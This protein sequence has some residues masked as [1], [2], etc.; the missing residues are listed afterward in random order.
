[1]DPYNHPEPTLFVPRER[2]FWQKLGG[3]SLSVSVV[4]HLLLLAV[5]VIWVFKIIPPPPPKNVDFMPRSGGGGTPS[6]ESHAKKQQLRIS[7][8]NLA[9]VVAMGASS[10]LVLPEPDNISQMSSVGSLSAGGLSAGLGGTGTGG[11]KGSGDGKGFGDGLAAG[12]STGHGNKNPFGM[13]ELTSGGLEG[14]F[15]DLKQ[16]KD[17]KPSEITDAGVMEALKDITKR[18]I[19]ERDFAK[20]FKAPGKLY[21]TKFLIPLM[22]AEEAPAAFDAQ[23]YVQP[24]RW[25]VVYRGVVKAPKSGKFSFVG[26]GD[27]VLVVRFNNRLVFDHGYTL[28]TTGGRGGMM[29]E[30]N[31]NKDKSSDAV[32]NFK[33]NSPMPVPTQTYKYATTGRLNREVDGLAVGPEFQVNA[34]SSYPIEIMISEIPGG[35]FST[36]LLIQESGVSYPKD[37]AGYPILPLFRLDHSLPDPALTGEA[38]P[39]AMDGPVWKLVPGASFRDI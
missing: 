17:L 20:Y 3:G 23:K 11:G 16:D 35:L 38:P 13:A 8:P 18:G 14:S 25:V 32:K 34:G 24:K 27:D 5:G 6:A 31:Y 4:L 9:R 28:A 36:A 22:S 39:Y 1:M 10:S 12:M 15:Y 29:S 33:R 2:T 37:P 26:A 19:K 7:Q 21:Q 30:A